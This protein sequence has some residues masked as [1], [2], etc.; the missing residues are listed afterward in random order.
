MPLQ[1][2]P[3]MAKLSVQIMLAGHQITAGNSV[4]FVLVSSLFRGDNSEVTGQRLWSLVI[5]TLSYTIFNVYT[6]F[7]C[8][9]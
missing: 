4:D 7:E 3:A 5:I 8:I 2:V 9:L 1:H 6:I